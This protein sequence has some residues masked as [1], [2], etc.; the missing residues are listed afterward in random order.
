MVQ[1]PLTFTA[2][3]VQ[4]DAMPV[5]PSYDT[6]LSKQARW[7]SAMA[8]AGLAL[9]LLC[10]KLLPEHQRY[11][12]VFVGLF[13]ALEIIGIVMAVL[14][15]LPRRWPSIANE[16]RQ[17]AELLDYDLPYQLQLIEWLQG[18]PRARLE[19]LSEYAEQRHQ[20]MQEKL[21]LFTGSIEKLGLLPVAIAL[22]VQFKDLRWPPQ[23]SWPEILLIFILVFAYAASL[24][25]VSIRLRLQLYGVLLKKAL[26][27]LDR[28]A[29]DAPT[30]DSV[31]LRALVD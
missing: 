4:I 9:S 3:N 29:Q 17:F 16:R 24:L 26:Q 8:G 7:G 30:A 23:P 28:R 22:Y 10:V 19:T 14:S 21:P 11:T 6:T 20:R 2:L 31:P 25:L 18:F 1:A 13:V 15:G 27:D 5:H 12:V